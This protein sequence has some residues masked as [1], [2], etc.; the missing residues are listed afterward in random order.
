MANL[1]IRDLQKVIEEKCHRGKAI[2]LIGARQVGKST[3]FS[4]ISKKCTEG[5]LL[6]NCDD[7]DTRH[8]LPMQTF[9]S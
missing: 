2:I 5:V 9:L 8:C 7:P 1:L 4:Q 6:L 3:L